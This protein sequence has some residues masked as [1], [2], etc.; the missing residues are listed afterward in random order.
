[1]DNGPI[2]VQSSAG[3]PI[4]AS[5]RV[6]YF[7]GSAWTSHSELMGLPAALLSTNYF[8]PMYD[9]VNH[10]SQLSF[11]NMGTSPTTVS[12]TI[13][14]VLKGIYSLAPNQVARV[15]YAGVNSG[16]VVIQSSGGVP[17]LAA[18]RVA[19]FNGSAWTSFSELIGL[20]SSQLST[21]YFFPWFDNV[22]I[23]TQLMFGVP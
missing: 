16:P 17:I 22:N 1:L 2:K 11:A 9:N 19:Y 12:V 23:D 4:F 15:S 18:K 5:L 21:S 13:N 8:F 6:G 10:N 3:V 7:N 20:P 14:G